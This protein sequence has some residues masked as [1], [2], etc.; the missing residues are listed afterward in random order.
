MGCGECRVVVRERLQ[1]R[2]PPACPYSAYHKA[3][4]S[5]AALNRYTL[6]HLNAAA[7]GAMP[8]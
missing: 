3:R 4:L 5:L 7:R 8:V 1:S 2:P 6:L